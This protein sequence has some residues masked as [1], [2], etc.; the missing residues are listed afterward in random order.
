MSEEKSYLEQIATLDEKKKAFDKKQA[1][2]RQRLQAKYGAKA[3]DRLAVFSKSYNADLLSMPVKAVDKIAGRTLGRFNELSAVAG[4]DLRQLDDK[5]WA[6]YLEA[7]KPLFE[8][9]NEAVKKATEK[10]K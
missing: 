5:Q 7:M 4:F 6:V 1:E 10:T 9:V 2:Q 8:Q 3:L